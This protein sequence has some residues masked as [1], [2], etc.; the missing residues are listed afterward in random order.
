MNR[1]KTSSIVS[2]AWPQA[3]QSGG[4]AALAFTLI[5]GRAGLQTTLL[6]GIVI[7]LLEWHYQFRKNLTQNP[8]L[9]MFLAPVTLMRYTS[10]T[11]FRIRTLCFLFSFT[12]SRRHLSKGKKGE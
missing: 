2:F 12:F 4:L 9:F 1:E 6:V 5:Y 3:F 8:Y 11:D 10:I 7:F